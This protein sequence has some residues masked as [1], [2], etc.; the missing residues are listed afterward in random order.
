MP[1]TSVTVQAVTD[2]YEG[3]ISPNELDVVF[4]AADVANGNQFTSSGDEILL[5]RNTH[6]TVA[7]TF[8]V[9]STPDER[10]RESDITTYSLAA[11]EFSAFG[12]IRK[13]GW[14]QTDGKIY[15]DGESA[16][17]GFAILRPAE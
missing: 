17:I 9:D 13:K 6:A 4:T 3:T 5:V 8:T 10:G 14:V 1:R 7:K 15:V 12:P 16:D 2:A 11:G